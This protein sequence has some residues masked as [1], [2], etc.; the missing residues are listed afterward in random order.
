MESY[1]E[2]P[3]TFT[4]DVKDVPYAKCEP[5]DRRFPAESERE[6]SSVLKTMYE[7]SRTITYWLGAKT[8]HAP[9]AIRPP[10]TAAICGGRTV[11]FPAKY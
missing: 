4:N 5:G 8:I 10:A 9:P 6:E 2:K 7:S 3:R 11:I 1:P